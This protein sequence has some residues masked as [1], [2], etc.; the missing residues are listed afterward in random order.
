[1]QWKMT[2]LKVGE[3]GHFGDIVCKSCRIKAV[4]KQ[5]KMKKEQNTTLHFKR[6]Y[7]YIKN[8]YE[9]DILHQHKH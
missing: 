2:I 9:N 8:K 5:S 4:Q 6:P 3:N 7:I 1:M